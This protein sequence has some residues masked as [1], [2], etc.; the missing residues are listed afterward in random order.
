M[1]SFTFKENRFARMHAK[2]LQW[3]E[4]RFHFVGVDPPSTTGFNL[5]AATKGEQQNAAKPF[6]LDPYGCH[7]GVLQTKRKQRNPF[8]RTAPYS[9]SCPDMK[10]LLSHC[11][12]DL[13]EPSHVPWGSS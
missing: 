13:I 5:E 6:E 4:S 1:I 12:P 11:G 3:P 10:E 7:S 9:L 8:S 2:A